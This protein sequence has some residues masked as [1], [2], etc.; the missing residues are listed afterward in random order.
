MPTTKKTKTKAAGTVVFPEAAAHIVSRELR[1]TPD[2]VTKLQAALDAQLPLKM[3]I[4][5]H[6]KVWSVIV[7]PGDDGDIVDQEFVPP[8]DGGDIPEDPQPTPP[9]AAEGRRLI[10]ATIK[11]YAVAVFRPEFER[12]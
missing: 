5:L 7:R 9:I 3:N 12:P 2:Q 10:G 11:V 1:F 6:S 8:D 4:G